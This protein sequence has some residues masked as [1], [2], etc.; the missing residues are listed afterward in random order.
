MPTFQWR[1]AAIA[2][3]VAGIVAT[4]FEIVL[5]WASSEPLPAILFRD[6][7]LAAAIVMGPQVLPPPSTFDASVMLTATLVHFTLSIVYGLTLCAVLSRWR[8]RVGLLRGLMVGAVFGLALYAINMY[9]F[10]FLFP[11]FAV[12]RDWITAA[13]HAVFGMAVALAYAIT[14]RKTRDVGQS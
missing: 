1:R 12:T 10:T 13:T 14:V 3:I 4:A 9:G 6:A 8:A 5:W 7:R 11:W 2:G